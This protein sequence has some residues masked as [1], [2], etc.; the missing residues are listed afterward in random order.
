MVYMMANVAYL[1]VLSPAEM[2]ISPAVAVVIIL[3]YL[4]ESVGLS[5]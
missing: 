4:E 1:G 2:L 5:G 3:L